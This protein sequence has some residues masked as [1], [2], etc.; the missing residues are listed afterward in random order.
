MPM[1]RLDVLIT[2]GWG[3]VAYN[4]VRSLSKRGLNVVAGT[5][6]FLGMTFFSRHTAQR[7]RHPF[8]TTQT[9]AFVDAAKKALY[10]YS[11]SV[12][13]PTSEDTLVVSRYLEIFQETGAVIPVAPFHVI[14][15]LY[16]KDQVVAL[17]ETVGIP[18]PKTIRP[19]SAMEIQGF[20]D[21][22]GYP[23]V[24]KLISSS[25]G[26]G[27]FLLNEQ[28]L[29]KWAGDFTGRLT[30]GD[31]IAQEC[32]GGSGFGVSMLF[33]SGRLRAKFTHKRL[34]EIRAEGGV[35]TSRMSVVNSQLEDYAQ[36]LL[37]RVKFHGVAMVEFRHDERTGKTWLLEVNPRFWGSLALAIRSGV[38]FPYLLYRMAVDGDVR[39]VSKYRTGMVVNWLL[40][41]LKARIT[42]GRPA[43]GIRSGHRRGAD[44]YDD[45]Y[46]DDPLAFVAETALSALKLVSRIWASDYLDLDIR[47]LECSDTGNDNELGVL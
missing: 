3:R 8:P 43:F 36:K 39:A 4:V 33:N 21:R 37:E 24:L 29:Q 31:F 27:V 11:P 5:D 40:G 22:Y 32:V 12:Y 23:I 2:Q 25:S 42:P 14:K 30:A 44:G 20:A 45:F 15:R 19:R 34:R 10:R 9:M 46:W 16:R 1:D 38:D 28:A 35:S 7:F 41:D 17:A 6:R 18:T 47:Q 13:L 26:R